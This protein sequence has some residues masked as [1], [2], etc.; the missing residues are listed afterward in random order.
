MAVVAAQVKQAPTD[1]PS[2]SALPPQR[3]IPVLG[4]P[5]DTEVLVKVRSSFP[6]MLSSYPASQEND[7]FTFMSTLASCGDLAQGCVADA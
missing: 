6:G 3:N 7:D 2:S 4:G 1:S 5:Q